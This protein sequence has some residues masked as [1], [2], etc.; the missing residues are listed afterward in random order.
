MTQKT[1]QELKGDWRVKWGGVVNIKFPNAQYRK[2]L[3]LKV[4]LGC[5]TW[6]ELADELYRLKPILSRE[7]KIYKV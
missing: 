1:A 5:K 4:A 2:L 3:E 7:H 6:E